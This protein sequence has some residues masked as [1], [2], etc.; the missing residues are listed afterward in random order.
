MVRMYKRV[1]SRCSY[2]A[3][4]LRTALTAIQNGMLKRKASNVYG[5]PRATLIKH[6]SSASTPKLGRFQRVFTDEVECELMMHIVEIQNRFYGIGLT[7]LRHIAFELAEQNGIAH[8]FSS[9]T[10]MAGEDW[11]AGFLERNPEL[12]LR[13]P[14]PT[15]LSIDPSAATVSHRLGR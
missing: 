1:S 4:T 14:E 3:E 12:S 15:S 7:E 6:L 5:I 8:P 10:T 13:R 9:K 2:S 11:A